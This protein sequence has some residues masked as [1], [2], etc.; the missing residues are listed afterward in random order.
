MHVIKRTAVKEISERLTH[1]LGPGILVILFLGGWQG[2]ELVLRT[3]LIPRGRWEYRVVSGPT[4]LGELT[5]VIRTEKG[6]IVSTSD[7][8]GSR[9][10]RTSL[11]AALPTLVPIASSTFIYQ[12]GEGSTAAQ[13][14]Y[15]AQGDSLFV[16]GSVVWSGIGR[17]RAAPMMIRQH[18]PRQGWYDNQS[19]DL[20]ISALPLE[21][22]GSWSAH[23]FD[24]THDKPLD[25][26]ITVVERT[27]VT[28]PAGAFEVWRV[29]VAG[30]GGSVQY[31]IECT[32]RV[33]VV[34]YLPAS[35]FRL[36]L[37]SPLRPQ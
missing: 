2:E 32:T 19:I 27:D 1:S 34:Q 35:E 29:D 14:T 11:T 15:E 3:D 25:I 13:L 17:P 20:L 5:S 7:M 33:L 18:L 9:V 24:P 4:L 16:T 12:P 10:Q 6:R 23:L 8:K 28:T 21:N 36:E 30:M 26:T 22:G 37:K 31:F